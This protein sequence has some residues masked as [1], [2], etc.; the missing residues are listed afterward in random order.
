MHIFISYSHIFN[1]GVIFLN[2]IDISKLLE[3]LSKMDKSELEAGIAKANEIL[4]SKD[5]QNNKK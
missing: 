2:N 4:K 5:I 1:V 3:T